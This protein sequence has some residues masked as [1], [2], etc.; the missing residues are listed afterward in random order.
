MLKC[1]ARRINVIF[2]QNCVG[3]AKKHNTDNYDIRLLLVT[4]QVDVGKEF[5]IQALFDLRTIF[6]KIN[7][8]DCVKKVPTYLYFE[9]A[10]GL[11]EL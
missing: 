11:H 3:L 1:W 4:G 9:H 2:S 5:F 6:E 8:Y 7:E 10:K